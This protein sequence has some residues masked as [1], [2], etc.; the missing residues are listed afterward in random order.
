MIIVATQVATLYRILNL[1]C[2]MFAI[3]L[4]QDVANN[5]FLIFHAM[6]TSYN[7]SLQTPMALIEPI[8]SHSVG[9]CC[10][11]HVHVVVCCC[12]IHASG[13][14]F[15]LLSFFWSV[16][17]LYISFIIPC[18]F[19]YCC[20]L[21]ASV[22]LSAAIDRKELFMKSDF[23]L[24]LKKAHSY[25]TTTYFSSGRSTTTMSLMQSHGQSPSKA[26]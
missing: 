23:L 10:S 20:Y 3:Q 6:P 17:D 19:S 24:S 7:W 26:A 9:L 18:T 12:I 25:T 16:V 11:L 22:F 15:M 2:A 4:W 1:E 14:A 13:V 5:D 8:L 21:F